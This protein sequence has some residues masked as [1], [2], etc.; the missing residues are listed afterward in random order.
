VKFGSINTGI[1]KVGVKVGAKVGSGVGS[2][3]GATVGAG[4]G[5]GSKMGDMQ[6]RIAISSMEV[7]TGTNFGATIAGIPN[8]ILM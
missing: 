5:N 7:T 8:Q 4:V 1:S 2:K 3:V 6:P